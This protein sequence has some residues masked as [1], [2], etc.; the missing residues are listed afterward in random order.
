MV[1]VTDLLADTSLALVP[2]HLADEA[3]AIRWV[4]TS[5]LAD[6]TPFL[7]GGEVVLTTGLEMKGWDRQWPAYVDRLAGMQ[8]AGIGFAI[9]LT[10]STPPAGLVAACR[11]RGMNL[12]EVPR[13]TTFVAISRTVAS[14]LEVAAEAAARAQ[15]A[16]QRQLTQAALHQDDPSALVS[17]L[18]QLV[19]GAA[20]LV[21]RDAVAPVGPRHDDLDLAVVSAEVDRIRPQGLHAATSVQTAEGTLVVQPI[22]LSGR[23]VSYLAVHV[24]GRVGD[25]ERTVIASGVALLGLTAETR[26]ERRD[27]ARRLRTRALE[28]LVW[29]DASS[30]AIVL[31]ASSESPVT[32]PPMVVMARA[33]GGADAMDDALAALE[34]D[35]ILAGRVADELWLLAAPGVLDAV[36]GEWGGRGLRVGVGDPVSLEDARRSHSNAGHALAV[37]SPAAPVVRWERMVGEGAMAVLDDDRAAAFATTFVTRL[38]GDR[39][40][41]QTLRSFLR[42]NGSR[43][44]VSEELGVHRNTVRNRVEQIERALDRSLDDPDVRVSAWIALQ[45]AAERSP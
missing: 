16:A 33:R 28:L 42:H 40:L 3:A 45:V 14:M 22:G 6:P 4:A 23:P 1:T 15:L 39:E 31:E 38:G 19:D 20:A 34:D 26:R 43:L 32:L 44:K 10:H 2:V 17:R 18:A 29:A 7:E 12:I 36:V 9:G 30:A 11:D 5:E 8:V 13:P 35:P 41:I 27:T 24:P 21:G 37:A 25:L